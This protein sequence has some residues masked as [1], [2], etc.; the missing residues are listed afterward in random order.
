M[1]ESPD[2]E[3]VFRLAGH[4]KKFAGEVLA[5]PHAEFAL[6]RAY[7]RRNGFDADRIECTTANAGAAVAQTW[8]SRV[9]ASDLIPDFQSTV[10]GRMKSAGVRLAAMPG[11]N[12]R[13][14]TPEESK[15]RREARK[16][17]RETVNHGRL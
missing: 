15:A 12:V 10:K 5:M 7:Y 4:L 2:L 3:F 6:W 1:D 16:Q 9:K 14:L 8:G 11:A 17:R 13:K